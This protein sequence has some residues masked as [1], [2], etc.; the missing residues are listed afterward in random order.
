MH[1]RWL[2]GLLE[3]QLP[4]V[5]T[6]DSLPAPH[7]SH[8]GCRHTVL[9]ACILLTTLFSLT[10]QLPAAAPVL[11]LCS[12][13][14]CTPLARC[15]CWR[16]DEGMPLRT[17]TAPPGVLRMGT[18]PSGPARLLAEEGTTLNAWLEAHPAALGDAVRQRFGGDLPFLFKVTPAGPSHVFHCDADAATQPAC[19]CTGIGSVVCLS[20]CECSRSNEAC[21][22]EL[23]RQSSAS[24]SCEARRNEGGRCHALCFQASKRARPSLARCAS[25]FCPVGRCCRWRPHCPS[26]RTRTR[27]SRSACMLSA[28]RSCPDLGLDPVVWVGITCN[29]TGV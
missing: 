1:N 20:G 12:A 6:A 13:W 5:R 24:T 3:Y 9:P 7:P 15:A 19:G 28:R 26:S 11:S 10:P 8:A 21:G 2:S 27:R 29:S 23:M 4:C 16:C 18:H 25:R 14:G 22:R 17:L